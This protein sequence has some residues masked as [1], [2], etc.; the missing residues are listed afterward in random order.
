MK[1]IKRKKSITKTTQRLLLIV[2]LVV[3]AV[4]TYVNWRF[5][6]SSAGLHFGNQ[7]YNAA[8]A[9]M[10][11]VTAMGGFKEYAQGVMDTYR[12]TP[13][14][15]RLD[16]GEE[17]YSRFAQFENS[18]FYRDAYSKLREKQKL[19]L[20]EDTYIAMLDPE[21]E[22]FVILIDPE[23]E[24]N[25]VTGRVG[26]WYDATQE[27]LDTFINQDTEAEETM[28]VPLYV[29]DNDNKKRSED[30]LTAGIQIRDEKGEIYAVAFADI[31]LISVNVYA[32]I[33]TALYLVV[34]I[35][36]IVIVMIAARIFMWRRIVGPI[37]KVADAANR[38]LK[39]QS[40]GKKE[41]RC[42]EG[43]D[44]HT[45]DEMEDLGEA[46]KNMES[47]IALYEEDLIKVTAERERMHTELSV[48]AKIQNALLPDRFPAYP[49]RKDVDIY[50]VMDPAKE[51]GGDFYDFFLL[52]Q[53]HLCM[54]I[55]DVS[56]KGIPAALFM[57]AS[58]IIIGSLAAEGYSPG[59]VLAKS[60]D[61][62]SAKNRNDMFVTA[63][64]GILDLTSG[65]LTAANAGH[66]YPVV[67]QAGGEYV[68]YKDKHSPALGCMEGIRYKEY[69]LVLEPGSTLFVYTDGVPEATDPDEHMYG[70]DRLLRLLNR[71][72]EK[73]LKEL[74]KAVREDVS[75]FVRE[76][77]QFDDLT[78]L[79]VRYNGPEM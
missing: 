9:T 54:V 42:F 16:A 40:E 59:E 22:R 69:S 36:V 47:S 18:D 74:L 79:C 62:I 1:R 32:A 49:D 61:R 26:M 23:N 29:I 19:F 21:T 55:A 52:D 73:N 27:E 65:V 14:D 60:N 63:W 6:K 76:A 43:L 78:M 13:E 58:M 4:S 3:F 24:V 64:F 71:S 51:V 35:F 53:D 30:T 28:P 56:G 70:T 11:D 34:M 75:I 45:R 33:Y 37:K 15:I 12:Q 46:L 72:K 5:E 39:N 67:Q 77:P 20:F 8:V 66:E 17:Y 10:N 41:Q 44:I 68:L 7:A 57:M 38:F 2:V 25:L 50:A 31:M 48:A